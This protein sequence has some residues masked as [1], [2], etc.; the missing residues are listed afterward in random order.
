MRPQ[1]WS[2]RPPEETRAVYEDWADTYDADITDRGYVTPLRIAEA[3]ARHLAPGQPILDFGCG[4]GISGAALA[5]KG[6]GP[7][8]GTD[9][10]P[11]MITLAKGKGHYRQL[12]TG[13]PGAIPASPGTYDAI[14][15]AGVISLGAAP[16]ETLRDLIAATGPGALIALSFNDP[17]IED[18]SYDAELNAVISEGTVTLISREHGPH[19]SNMDMGSDV[20]L[21]RR[22]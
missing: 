2:H 5:A 21:L 18:G 20:I 22:L 16:P 10:T 6:L 8:D 3:L 13:Q 4:T 7:I 14:V 12:W 19:L 1:L 11:G 15:A 17:S 9:I